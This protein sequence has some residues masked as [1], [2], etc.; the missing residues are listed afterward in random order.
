MMER[1]EL[2]AYATPSDKAMGRVKVGHSKI[3]GHKFRIK[4]QFGTSNAEYP[5]FIL[6]GELPLGKTDHHIH[7]QLLKNGIRRVEDSPGKEFFYA[8]F[9]DVK[10][11]Y[12][13]VLHGTNRLYSFELRSEQKQAIERARKWFLKEYDDEIIKGSI[14]PGRFLIN[15]KMR[16]GKCF[17]SI[18]LAKSL[19]AKRTLIV[20]YK[21]DVIGEWLDTVN[22]HVDFDGW[23]GI[24]AKTK[25]KV[26][27]DPNLDS[28][29]DF[30][31]YDHPIVLCVS[32]QDLWIDGDGK[33]KERLQ[34]I[35]KVDWDL[36][37]FDEVHYG[38]RTERASH[39]LNQIKFNYRLDLS[40]TPFKLIE[41]DDFCAQQVFTYSYLDEQENKRIERENDPDNQKQK[42]YRLMPDLNISAIEITEKDIA[43]QRETFETDDIDFSLNKLFETDED[44]NFVYADSVDHFIDGLTRSDHSARSISVFGKLGQKLNCPS[45]RHTVWWL[46]RVDS[47]KALIKKLSVHP[48][49]SNFVLIDASGSDAAKT[50]NEQIIAREKSKVEHAIRDVESNPSKIG[51]ITLT[52]GR[53][54]TGVTIKEWDSILILNDTQSAESYFQAIFRVQSRWIDEKKNEILKPTAWVFDFAITRCLSVTYE[55]ASNISDQIDQLASFEG[56]SNNNIPTLDIVTQ[57]LCDTLDIKRFYEGDLVSTP[58]MAKDIFEVLNHEGSKIALARRITSNLLVNFAQLKF[59]DDRLR[60]ILGKIKGYRTQNVADLSIEKLV[61]IGVDA[62]LLTEVKADPNLDSEDKSEIIEDFYEKEKDKERKT[63]K[64]WYAT[65]IKRLA[66]CMADFIYMTYE[67]E[68]NIDDVI[69]TKSPQFFEIMTGISKDDFSELCNKGFIKKSPLNRIVREFR[70]QETTSLNPEEFILMNISSLR[71]HH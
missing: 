27:T 42:I 59:V 16:F 30:H 5:E 65:Q 4:Q 28:H 23:V 3:G 19:N 34:N 44:G 39:I 68:I 33:T 43:D 62:Q 32:L 11:A 63:Y 60:D 36:I 14:H 64:Q 56:T 20:T 61:Q 31:E 24:R 52:C 12:H 15:A 38:S 45:K 2:Y 41:H 6:L 29:S 66:I 9:D 10:R 49:F 17:T 58:T 47:I 37:I 71:G 18:H 22:E 67:R 54:L 46:K 51:T 26:S 13:Q 7:A 53:F 69:E 21:P 55:C 48:Y 50:E 57:K 1:L 25:S 40:G 35:P 8:T 70:D